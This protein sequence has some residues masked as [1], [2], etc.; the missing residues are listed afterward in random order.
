LLVLEFFLKHA[1]EKEE[2]ATSTCTLELAE[3]KLQTL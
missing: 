1:G 3:A 2:W